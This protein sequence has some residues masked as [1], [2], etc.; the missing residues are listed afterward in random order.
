[1]LSSMHLNERKGMNSH[2]TR[3]YCMHI[4]SKLEEIKMQFTGY[5]LLTEEH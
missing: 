1:M 5:S 2:G 4:S 3:K